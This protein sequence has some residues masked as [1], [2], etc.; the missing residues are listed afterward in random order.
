MA[1][2]RLNSGV[3]DS[4]YISNS[5]AIRLSTYINFLFLEIIIAQKAEYSDMDF[6]FNL[7]IFKLQYGF[8][9]FYQPTPNF[10]HYLLREEGAY[11]C[12]ISL[13]LDQ[14]LKCMY[15]IPWQ[16]LFSFIS[17]MIC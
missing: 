13:F 14:M 4:V 2:D 15:S 10:I 1:V 5:F 16:P 7:L 11:P 12:T 3:R 9:F 6:N 8:E 17:L